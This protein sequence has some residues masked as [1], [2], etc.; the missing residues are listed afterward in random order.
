MSGRRRMRAD[1]KAYR[2]SFFTTPPSVQVTEELQVVGRNGAVVRLKFWTD[3]DGNPQVDM[4]R[5]HPA[6]SLPELELD[7]RDGLAWGSK[8]QQRRWEAEHPDVPLTTRPNSTIRTS[9]G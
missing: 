7:P 5:I 3:L 2:D 4:H 8:R 6:P 9:E 1:W